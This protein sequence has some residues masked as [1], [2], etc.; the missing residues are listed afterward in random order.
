MN[1][2][3]RRR[4]RN[5]F[6]TW[7]MLATVFLV[8]TLL[9]EFVLDRGQS[10][11]ATEFM[12]L[13]SLVVAIQSYVGN[14]GLLSFGHVAFFAVGAYIAGLAAM[15]PEKKEQF[16]P[17]L[18]DWVISLEASL[19][20][21]IL[22]AVIGVAIF[23]AFTG[24]PIS[25]MHQSVIPMATLALLVMTHTV[26]NLWDDVTR[27]TRGLVSVPD[28]VTTW[29]VFA[30]AVAITGAALLYAA[31]P[32]GLRLQVVREDPIAAAALGIRVAAT[33]FTGWM[34]SAV[35]MAIGSAVWA[36]NSLA[37]G[38]EQ[39]FFA[40]T[41]SLLAM[42]IIGGTGSVTGAIAG[43]A[44]VS[45]INESLRGLERGFAIGPIQVPEL[46]GLIQLV[47]ALA[48]LLLLIW[49][50]AG[51]FGNRELSIPRRRR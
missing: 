29:T 6:I 16:L 17:N 35:L 9:A 32:A 8:V 38:P 30:T 28:L 12:I 7:A 14:S 27:G 18:P 2:F 46:P 48:L 26:V 36:L 13:A 20:L 41:F 23:A 43:T 21:A 31:S 19:P 4:L 15:S 24:V 3:S 45:V 51:L 25:R 49:R 11:M 1:T 40:Q 37:F 33:R 42:L 47:V 22:I 50:P 39:F 44:I 34:V 10:R 5:A